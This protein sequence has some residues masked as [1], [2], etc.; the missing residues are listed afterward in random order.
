MHSLNTIEPSESQYRSAEISK[1]HRQ[2]ITGFANRVRLMVSSTVPRSYEVLA[3][4]IPRPFETLSKTRSN[5]LFPSTSLLQLS[6]SYGI[7]LRNCNSSMRTVCAPPLSLLALESVSQLL[8][9]L[10]LLSVCSASH[11]VGRTICL[12]VLGPPRE[13]RDQVCP[14]YRV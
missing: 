2:T 10:F 1:D 7:V 9:T 11:V 4:G 13:D 14:L 5:V 3:I 12:V 8:L 6:I